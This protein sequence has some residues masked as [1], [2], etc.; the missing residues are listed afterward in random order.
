M[1]YK[2][3]PSDLTFL[4]DSCKHCFVF[5]VKHGIPQP[6]IPLPGVFTTIA[7]L[8]KNHYSGKRTEEF[9]PQLPP[10]IVNYGEQRVQSIPITFDDLESTCVIAGRFDVVAELD[11]GSF[12]VL[13]FKTGNPSEEKVDMYG[14][15]LHA[16]AFALEN[17]A[18]GALRLSPVSR[19]GLL[20]YTPDT[21]EFIGNNRQVLTGQMSWHEVKRDDAAFHRFLHDV[22]A[23]LDGPLPEPDAE[24]CD[25]CSYRSDTTGMA[26]TPTKGSSDPKSPAIVP[27][28][29]KCGDLMKKRTGKFGEFW[30]CVNYPECKGTRQA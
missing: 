26:D 6:S 18:Q 21:C 24:T 8:Q 12:A 19:L 22:V 25:W 7:N 2:L 29:P 13:D 15:Q 4:Y 10:G 5:K 30:G 27:N 11:D 28:C 3:S 17:P 1:N 14:R 23:L 16:Y 9:C 20:Y